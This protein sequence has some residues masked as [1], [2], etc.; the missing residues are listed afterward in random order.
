MEERAVLLYKQNMI[1]QFSSRRALFGIFLLLICLCAARAQEAENKL[2]AADKRQIIG[3]L[4]N[5]KFKRSPEKTIYISAKNISDEIQKDFPSVKN[6]AIRLVSEDEAAD[7]DACAYEFG[8]FQFIEKYVSVTFGNCR[9]G[10]AYDFVKYGSRW[11]SV[12]ATVTR[13]LFY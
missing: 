4:L 8:E 11:K 12:A 9:E 2:S 1:S 13:E 6:K 3:V 7:S 5:E 10:L